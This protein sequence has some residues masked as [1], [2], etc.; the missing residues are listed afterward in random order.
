VG[1]KKE[2]SL[3]YEK[4]LHYEDEGAPSETYSSSYERKEGEPS[5][6]YEEPLHYEEPSYVENY[7]EQALDVYEAQEPFVNPDA[8][9]TKLS[10]IVDRCETGQLSPDICANEAVKLVE[11]YQSEVADIVSN[12]SDEIPLEAVEEL[13]ESLVIKDIETYGNEQSDN[14]NESYDFPIEE[15][16]KCVHQ[17]EIE[18]V[19]CPDYE[20]RCGTESEAAACSEGECCID[21]M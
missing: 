8:Y 10:K 13:L 19:Q 14:A 3:Y 4:Q 2:P 11:A 21:E 15:V 12:E 9:V 17:D 1:E 18:C 6:Y 16:I 7:G 20:D 5:S